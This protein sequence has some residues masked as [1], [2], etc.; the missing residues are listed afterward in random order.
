MTFDVEFYLF[1]NIRLPITI[2]K[3][4]PVDYFKTCSLS[5]KFT[6]SIRIACL[7]DIKNLTG[8]SIYILSYLHY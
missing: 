5:V 6:Q 1:Q 8:R 7:W 4:Y 3:K 2:S